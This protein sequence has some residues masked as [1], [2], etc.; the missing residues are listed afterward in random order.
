MKPARILLALD[1]L[2][3]GET[4][5]LVAIQYAKMSG[6]QI[7][8]LHV[9]PPHA[10]DPST[11]RPDEGCARA[12][13]DAVAAQIH[14]AGVPAAIVVRGGPPACTIVEEAH[15]ID[16]ATLEC[17]RSSLRASSAACLD[18]R[19]VGSENH[20]ARNHLQQIAAVACRTSRSSSTELTTC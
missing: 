18:A 19:E 4:K 11:V 13:L 10:F 15:I 17:G 7:V 14:S 2:A 12:Y 16:S 5:I 8:L 1:Q 6:A 20:S 3:S 9:L